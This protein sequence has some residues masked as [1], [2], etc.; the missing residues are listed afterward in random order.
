MSTFLKETS[1]M[2]PISIHINVEFCVPEELD[3]RDRQLV[4]K[5]KLM[6]AHAYSPY[7]QFSVGAALQLADG[8]VFCGCN[9]ENAAYPVGLCA[10]RSA[11]YAAGAQAPGIP[12]VTIAIA[13]FTHGAFTQR[14]VSPC[15][16]CR[17]ALLEAE[18]RYKQP[19]RVLLYGSEGVYIIPSVGDLL[20][21]NFDGSDLEKHV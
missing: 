9:Q 4:E 20:P 12:P 10:E 19:I 1:N 16:S 18:I 14:P 17:Q 5:A 7:S 15:G 3:E 6:T 11:F 2:K 21:F 13:A 8:Q